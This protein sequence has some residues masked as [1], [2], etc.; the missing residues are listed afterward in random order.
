MITRDGYTGVGASIPEPSNNPQP[1]NNNNQPQQTPATTLTATVVGVMV[2]QDQPMITVPLQ[3]A[4][5]MNVQ[6]MYQMDNTQ[7]ACQPNK[8][9]QPQ[10]NT[11]H[12]VTQDPLLTQG[13]NSMIAKVDNSKNA[14]KVAAEIKTLGVGAADAKASINQQL[15]IF[16][17]IGLVLGAIGGIALAVAA[18]G[19]VNTMI[20]AILERT[21]ENWCDARSW[22]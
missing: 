17:I 12:L 6:Q 11:F 16:N 7:N 15:T 14:A 5:A 18:I 10:S 13:Y 9:C 4:N 22:F 2:S 21:R 1:G 20:M 3:W 19:V 8:P